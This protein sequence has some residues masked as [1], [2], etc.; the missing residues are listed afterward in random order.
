MGGEVSTTVDTYVAQKTELARYLQAEVDRT[1][2]RDVAAKTDVSKTAIDNIIKGNMTEL[3]KLET[4]DKFAA[5]YKMPLWKVIEMAGI[6]LG[7]S[8][9]VSE[10]IQRLGAV[11][12]RMPEFEPIVQYLLKLYPEDL[13]GVVAYL[14]ALDR[15]RNR[16]QGWSE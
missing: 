9:S 14:E 2:L 3:P 8:L 4:L 6:D 5:A 16:D 1:S 12:E 10:T 7:L 11:A 13:R 15:Q